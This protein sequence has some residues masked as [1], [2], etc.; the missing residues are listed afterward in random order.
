MR[1]GWPTLRIGKAGPGDRSSAGR[2]LTQVSK[3][4]SGDVEG[5]AAGDRGRSLA[6]RHSRRWVE[7]SP[8]V[9]QLP[10]TAMSG[11]LLVPAPL[12]VLA[13]MHDEV[14]LAGGL[15]GTGAAGSLPSA[16]C[17]AKGLVVGAAARAGA[18]WPTV[19]RTVG[20]PRVGAGAVA[21]AARTAGSAGGTVTGSLT[22]VCDRIPAPY[23]AGP[24]SVASGVGAFRAFTMG[25]TRPGLT[26]GWVGCPGS[27]RM[28]RTVVTAEVTVCDPPR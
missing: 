7:A 24:D 27:E 12:P 1:Q 14:V 11:V 10:F 2:D 23:F 6:L 26:G 28:E 25:C 17:L 5:C 19:V 22:G 4:Q 15:A 21:A 8:A 3:D 13:V 9:A 16:N 20:G 18:A